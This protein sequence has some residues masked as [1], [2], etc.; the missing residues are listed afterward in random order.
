MA[1]LFTAVLHLLHVSCAVTYWDP[2]LTLYATCEIL[3][4]KSATHDEGGTK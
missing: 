3:Q 2:S 4:K 1:Q